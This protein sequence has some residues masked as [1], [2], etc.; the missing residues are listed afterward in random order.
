MQAGLDLRTASAAALEAA[1]TASYEGASPAGK[2]AQGA[3]AL[4]AAANQI[5]LEDTNRI[6]AHPR[7]QFALKL[8]DVGGTDMAEAVDRAAGELGIRA[9]YDLLRQPYEKLMF[10]MLFPG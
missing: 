6:I 3:F 7:M 1:R 10:I 9:A 2:K 5:S 8:K 4:W